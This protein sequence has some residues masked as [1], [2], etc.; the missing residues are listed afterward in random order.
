MLTYALMH[1]KYVYRCFD[2]GRTHPFALAH[3]KHIHMWLNVWITYTH[4]C[5]CVLMHGQYTHAH[6][7]TRNDD[8]GAIMMDRRPN[9]KEDVFYANGKFRFDEQWEIICLLVKLLS[10][11]HP[12]FLLFYI[13][14]DPAMIIKC[15]LLYL[16]YYCWFA[17]CICFIGTHLL[18]TY[19]FLKSGFFSFF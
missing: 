4:V 12:S 17:A 3:R 19:M 9:T 5:V 15:V 1:R 6:T 14:F 10:R 13:S 18:R 11:F 16:F 2:I 8:E 7:S